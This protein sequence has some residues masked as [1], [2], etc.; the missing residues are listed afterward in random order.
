[1]GGLLAEELKGDAQSLQAKMVGNIR[2]SADKMERRL[3][4]LLDF[5]R[6]QAAA[7]EL[8]L[9][10]TSVKTAIEE[11]TSLCLSFIL[12]KKQTLD[13]DVPDYL[14]QAVLDQLRFERIITN[15]LT[16]ASKF[17]P[18]GGKIR[19]RA[20]EKNG[21]LTVEVRDSGVGIPKSELERIF[22]PYYRGKASETSSSGLGLGLAIVEELAKLHH[23]RVWVESKPGKGSAF[24][25]SLPIGD[26]GSDEPRK[27]D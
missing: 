7:V 8:Q 26:G 21:N 27:G 13:V 20:R 25:F 22:E 9:Q 5:A 4:D 19:L 10:P 23:G 15:L 3:D 16:N 18:E 11:A 1:M 12:S 6:M 24:T 14:P 2:R 17:T